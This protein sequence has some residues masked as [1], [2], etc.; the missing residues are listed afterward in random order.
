V[1]EGPV[2]KGVCTTDLSLIIQS[3]DASLAALTGVAEADA[4]G[5]ALSELVPDLEVR[6]LL[7]RLRRVGETGVVEVLAPAF[8]EYLIPTIRERYGLHRTKAKR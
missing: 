4:R 6:G 5:R 2:A 3:W 7:A 8:H 1:S